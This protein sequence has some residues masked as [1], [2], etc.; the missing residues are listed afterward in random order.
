MGVFSPWKKLVA[1]LFLGEIA[2]ISRRFSTS[3]LIRGRFALL[4]QLCWGYGGL[5]DLG[6][7]VGIGVGHCERQGI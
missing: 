1:G 2:Q 6:L 4:P 3:H 5:G 7:K